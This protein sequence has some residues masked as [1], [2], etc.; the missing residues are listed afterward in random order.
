MTTLIKIA[1]EKG[2][3]ELF[4]LCLELNAEIPDN[5]LILAC[6]G[7]CLEIIE[8]LF[9]WG[10]KP[11]KDAFLAACSHGNHEMVD[12]F[13]ENNFPNELYYYEDMYIKQEAFK[14]VNT[15]DL[16]TE[17]CYRPKYSEEFV[18]DLFCYGSDEVIEYALNE[19]DLW[20]A[21]N[22]PG[23]LYYEL[24]SRYSDRSEE[25]NLKGLFNALSY[26]MSFTDYGGRNLLRS[27]TQDD[28]W[29]IIDYLIDNGLD[30][31]YFCEDG[32]TLLMYGCKQGNLE[33][34]EKV[35]CLGVD[36][37]AVDLRGNSA[38][39]YLCCHGDDHNLIEVVRMM[40]EVADQSVKDRFLLRA[41]E[42]DCYLFV[43]EALEYGANV[44]TFER[45]ERWYETP[46][47]YALDNDNRDMVVLL[48]ENGADLQPEDLEEIIKELEY[49][50]ET[51]RALR[52]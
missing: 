5:A 9:A 52:A 10:Y 7:G 2:C 33:M 37:N 21:D 8:R 3:K 43:S 38:L 25:D 12:L 44:E 11:C 1:L 19:Y 49:D 27:I 29:W 30:L 51:F 15:I 14:N 32:K 13:F 28:A 42:S 39:D 34:I 20:Y 36:V 47:G 48:V 22:V 26:G 4:D 6:R 24:I 16:I 45:N 17:V 18:D 35:L 31:D 41:C 23:N 40:L 46:L 50:L